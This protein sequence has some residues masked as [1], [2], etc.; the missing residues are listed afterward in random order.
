MG[1]EMPRSPGH[2]FD[3]S[4]QK[5]L[6]DVSFNAYVEQIWKPFCAPRMGAPSL[7]PGRYFRMHIIGHFEGIDSEL[8]Q[9]SDG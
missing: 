6:S 3:D 8:S 7:P 9:R 5:L 1:G 2:G 4:L